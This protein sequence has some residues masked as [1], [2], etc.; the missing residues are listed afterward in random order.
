MCCGCEM[1]AY[2]RW[3]D[4][5]GMADMGDIWLGDNEGNGRA[6]TGR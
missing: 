1:R 4:T 2:Q 5:R 6:M 3:L